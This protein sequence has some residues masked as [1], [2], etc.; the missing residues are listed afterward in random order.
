MKKLTGI[1]GLLIL[2]C[3]GGCAPVQK[4]ATFL[5][6]S[7]RFHF[8]GEDMEEDVYKRQTLDIPAIHID[9]IRLN[10]S[11]KDVLF[12]FILTAI[13]NNNQ[14]KMSGRG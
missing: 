4:E 5:K 11:L 2:C 12:L 3:I 8:P 14:L 7:I 6:S 9:S 1:A 13:C 10:K